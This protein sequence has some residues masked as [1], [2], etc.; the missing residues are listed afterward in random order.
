MTQ[1]K[2]IFADYISL[3]RADLSV[4]RSIFVKKSEVHY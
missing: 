1:I 2:M 4:Q 3:D